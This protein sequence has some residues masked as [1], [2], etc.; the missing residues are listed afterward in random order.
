M[1]PLGWLRSPGGQRTLFF[2]GT[3]VLVFVVWEV[4]ARVTGAPRY[5]LPT[6]SLVLGKL[7][8]SPR[9]ILPHL[10]TTLMEIGVGYLLTVAISIPLAVSIAYSRF[11]DNT[12]YPIIVFL[13]LI[14]KIALAPLFIVWFGFG[15][16]PKIVLVF[17]LSFFP[18]IV[19]ATAGF[20]SISPLLLHLANSM[21][22]SQW[23]IFWRIRLP[24]ALPHIFSGLKVSIA[25]AT[26]GAIVAEFVGADAGLGYLLLRAH[27]DLNTELLFG[28]LLVLSLIG[29]ILFKTI[30]WLERLVIPW[31]ISVRR[32][33]AGG[34]RAT[35]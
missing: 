22:G 16:M 7:L 31:H 33:L 13:Q 34:E 20:K 11:L 17:L 25:F 14:P 9:L 10:W 12:L 8:A 28:I 27:G 21:T 23:Q 15:F 32:E 3:G 1:T 29:V 35:L 19:D 24:N 30:E 18:L 26:V 5:I 4:G 6:P 2:L